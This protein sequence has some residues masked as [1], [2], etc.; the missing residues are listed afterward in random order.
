MTKSKNTFSELIS[1][2][3]GYSLGQGLV[4]LCGMI[5]MPIMTR[6]LSKE[7]YGLMSLVFLTLTFL[8]MFARMG[9]Q[10]AT[11]RVF[12]DYKIK[13]KLELQSEGSYFSSWYLHCFRILENFGPIWG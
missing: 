4:I 11:T 10:Q 2:I 5:S 3:W 6:L 1:H 12:H 7:Q 13:G 9:F 8:G